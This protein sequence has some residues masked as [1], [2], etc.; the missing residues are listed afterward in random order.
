MTF[1]EYFIQIAIIAFILA[2]S[3]IYLISIK[4]GTVKPVLAT[5]LFISVATILSFV[6]NFYESGLQGLLA[7]SYNIVDSVASILIF[8]FV[9]SR[10]DIR[11]NFTSFEKG[12]LGAVVLVFVAWLLS[13]Q[14]VLAHLCLQAILVIAYLPTLVHLWNAQTN[15]ESITT[16]SLN[17]FAAIFGVI[18]PVKT[19]AILPIVYGVR[20][21]LSCLAVIILSVRLQLGKTKPAASIR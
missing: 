4:R 17:A 15:T 14:N 8:A 7:N 11:K 1:T 12:C 13:G 2:Y 3:S 18:E 5:W 9:L 20:S 21:I 19:G 16:W 10:K 6:T